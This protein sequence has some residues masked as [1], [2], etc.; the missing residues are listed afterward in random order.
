GRVGE[1]PADLILLNDDDL[2][3]AKIRLDPASLAT[4]TAAI[5]EFAEP[6]PQAVC[7]TLAW[8]MTRDAELPARSYVDLVLAGI[9]SVSAA[10]VV[11]MLLL[12][13]RRAAEQYSDPAW[14]PAGLAA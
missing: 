1:A 11:Q 13:A 6:L 8:D 9:G 4:L 3:Y 10:S 14:R 12:Q 7:W 5:G 2:T